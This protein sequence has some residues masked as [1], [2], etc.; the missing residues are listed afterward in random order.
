MIF[1]EQQLWS[2]VDN[3]TRPLLCVLCPATDWPSPS[4]PGSLLHCG[5]GITDVVNDDGYHRSWFSSLVVDTC[6]KIGVSELIFNFQFFVFGLFK[7]G[8]QGWSRVGNARL[9]RS[10]SQ[11]KLLGCHTGVCLFRGFLTFIPFTDAWFDI[12]KSFVHMSSIPSAGTFSLLSF[13]PPHLVL[14]VRICYTEW[15]HEKEICESCCSRC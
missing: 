8:L 5:P 6:L 4:H 1:L 15:G 12:S 9:F 10:H 7:V 2:C 14:N 13:P 11:Y 3:S